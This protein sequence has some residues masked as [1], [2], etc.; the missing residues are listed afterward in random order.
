MKKKIRNPKENKKKIRKTSDKK[1]KM[2]FLVVYY[3]RTGTTKKLAEDI[4][5][6]LDADTEE[7]VDLKNRDGAVGWLSSGK[8]ASLGKTTDLRVIVRDPRDYDVVVIGTPTWAGN[9]TPAMRTYVR[10]HKDKFG[11]VACFCTMGGDNP[12]KVLD[13][14]TK[15]LGKDPLAMIHAQSDLVK[16]NLYRDLL[17]DFIEKIKDNSKI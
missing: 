11:K 2:K 15:E 12:G 16:K 7:I 5:K 17:G 4:A 14:F 3:S 8:D 1:P 9:I 10:C 6:H 13:E